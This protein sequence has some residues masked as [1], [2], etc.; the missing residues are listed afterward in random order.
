MLSFVRKR[1][2]S[3][4]SVVVSFSL[5]VWFL[6]RLDVVAFREMLNH[7]SFFWVFVGLVL[8]LMQIVLKAY[9][10]KYMLKI[11]N[12]LLKNT[13]GITGAY[14]LLKN[15]LPAGLGDASIFFLLKKVIGVRYSDSVGAFFL[16]NTVDFMT[17]VLIFI[18]FFFSGTNAEFV[19]PAIPVIMKTLLAVAAVLLVFFYFLIYE[20]RAFGF[21]TE[22]ALLKRSS[23]GKRFT[24][25]LVNLR[26]YSLN[27]LSSE[28]LFVLALFSIGLWI[29]LYLFSVSSCRA[30]QA[31]LSYLEIF[32]IYIMMWQINLIPIKGFFNLG[33]HELGWSLPLTLM[34]YSTAFADLVAFG[35]HAVA[36]LNL[37][38]AS[39]ILMVFFQKSLTEWLA[40]AMKP[41]KQG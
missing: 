28:S 41:E 33:S 3:V 34:G 12:R 23:L 31:N 14:A 19:R 32:I 6:Y 1:K 27:L 8:F 7:L 30:I 39:L 25:F 24:S 37:A 5:F 29:L 22:L 15:T 38:L 13:V 21:V 20:R 18:I 11:E 9:R 10:L 40:A 2:K 16:L 17:S 26:H 36:L 35:T 4:F